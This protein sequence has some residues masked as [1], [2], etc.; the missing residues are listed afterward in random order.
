MC[1][2]KNWRTQ[3]FHEAPIAY[4]IFISRRENH[5]KNKTFGTFVGILSRSAYVCGNGYGN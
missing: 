3:I 4:F 5:E 2:D 1:T